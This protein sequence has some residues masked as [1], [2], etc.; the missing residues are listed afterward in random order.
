[1]FRDRKTPRFRH[2]IKDLMILNAVVAI[3]FALSM[4]LGVGGLV[5][6]SFLT[7]VMIA[8][9]VWVEIYLYRKKHGFWYHW[10]NPRKP[11]PRYERPTDLEPYFPKVPA[12]DEPT[13][14]R[15]RTRLFETKSP[16]ERVSRAS[17]LLTVASQFEASGR[18]D[19]AAT[20]YHQILE[21]FPDADEAR[22][23]AHWLQSFSEK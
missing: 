1:M 7:L 16:S 19:A 8:P 14:Q 11:R 15:A 22:N 17:I 3:A 6:L 12:Q 18:M 2:R 21:R 4:A 9:L 10:Q 13:R 5:V 23:A 20:V